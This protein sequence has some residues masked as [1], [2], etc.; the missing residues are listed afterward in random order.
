MRKLQVS[1]VTLIRAALAVAGFASFIVAA[2]ANSKI[3]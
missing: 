1:K 3:F 2:G